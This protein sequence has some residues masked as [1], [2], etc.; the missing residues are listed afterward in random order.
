MLCEGCHQRQATVHLTRTA[1]PATGEESGPAKLDLCQQC[2]ETQLESKFNIKLPRNLICISDEY[3]TTLLDLLEKDHPEAFDNHDIDA[4]RCG[5]KL[6]RDFLREQFKKDNI[7]VSEEVFDM[8]LT[9]FWS[10]E[11]YAR[12]KKYRQ[13]KG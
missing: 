5:S 7:A 9:S 2:A 10:G 13:K 8:L 4:C 1:P 11:F 6:T 3:R 12:A